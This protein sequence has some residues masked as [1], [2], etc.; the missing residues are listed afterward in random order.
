MEVFIDMPLKLSAGSN[1]STL[2][3]IN[4]NNAGRFSIRVNSTVVTDGLMFNLDAGNSN[5]YNGSGTTWY[6]I[7]GNSR[8]ATLQNT[9]TYSTNNGGYFSFDDTTYEHATI[10]NIGNLS[11]FTVEAWC[12]VSKS[13]TGKVTSVVCNQ[14]DLSTKLNYSIG[15]NRAPTSYNMSFGY[16]NGS[17]RNV[18]GFAASLNTWYHLVGTYD[19]TTLK[20]YNNNVLDTQLSY[21]GTP[22]SGGEVRIARRWDSSATDAIN[23]F[24]GDVAQVRIY[25]KALNTTEIAQNYNLYK[26]RYGL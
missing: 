21:T 24:A 11:T 10:P 3:L 2:K 9:P 6:D 16:F 17:W 8:N 20:F 1:P 26:G 13:L 18:N 12:R 15:T 23:Y 14:F 19:G 7:S 4:S 25:S 22:S 5:S